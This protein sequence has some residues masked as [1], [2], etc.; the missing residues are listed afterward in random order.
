MQLCFVIIIILYI[1]KLKI[2]TPQKKENIRTNL[3]KLIKMN[4]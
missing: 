2:D 4:S 3:L 1:N